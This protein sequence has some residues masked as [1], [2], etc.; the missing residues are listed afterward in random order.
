VNLD[1]APKAG[2]GLLGQDY[3]GQRI[4]NCKL[5]ISAVPPL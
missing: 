5:A 4:V 1:A 2:G 3:D